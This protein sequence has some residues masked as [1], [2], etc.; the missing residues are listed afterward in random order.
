[1]R[2]QNKEKKRKTMKK[3]ENTCITSRS[4]GELGK[5]GSKARFCFQ[6]FF[7]FE[8]GH[9]KWRIE[10]EKERI[11]SEWRWRWRWRW[12]TRQ[13]NPKKK[14]NTQK[15]KPSEGGEKRKRLTT[16]VYRRFPTP[17]DGHDLPTPILGFLGSTGR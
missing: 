16:D 4:D 17:F 14:K 2:I 6:C 5:R 9:R 13:T 7:P 10:E 1:M 11:S 3:T 15:N 12:A 8:R